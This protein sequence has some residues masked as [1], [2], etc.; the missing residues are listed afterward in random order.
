ME[1][2]GFE[3][4]HAGNY[5][6]DN[7]GVLFPD[8]KSVTPTPDFVKRDTGWVAGVMNGTKHTPFS[9]IKSF[10][11]DITE[12]EARAK[13]YITGNEKIDE[14]FELM[15]RATLPTTIY[16]KQK[17]D[18]DDVIDITDFDVIM[19]LRGEMRLMLDEEIARAVL[20]GDGRSNVSNDK[21]KETSVRPI[22]T[23]AELYAT[24]VELVKTDV[25]E[26]IDEIVT[27]MKYYKGSGSP[28]LY[29][30]P[31]TITALLL[32]KDTLG[33][34]LYPTL[35]ELAAGLRVKDIVEV[36]VMSG[37]TSETDKPL[38]GII[39]NLSDYTIGADKGG[40]VNAFDDFDINFNQYHYLIE[41]RI[42]GALTKPKSAIVLELPV[43]DLG[44][45]G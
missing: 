42:S 37:V 41:T 3:L 28:T 6:L 19:W 11:A 5:G 22:Y 10:S 35:T 32:V 17:L 23:D 34:R 40:D 9:R 12:D 26:Q 14:V 43:P 4:Q 21:I 45:V 20:I 38:F 36:E 39:V 2:A 27:A 25:D 24:H 33:R 30:A 44:E 1:E 18:R 31:D 29:A 13:G 16:K 15:S 7:I 8:A